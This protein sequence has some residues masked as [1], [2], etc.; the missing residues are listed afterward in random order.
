MDLE[1][2]ATDSLHQSL[3]DSVSL[4]HN[5]KDMSNL[6]T[7]ESNVEEKKDAL[8]ENEDS[9]A[10]SKNEMELDDNATKEDEWLDILGSGQ[11]LKKVSWA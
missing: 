1:M 8:K 3:E 9:S 6:R 10:S 2:S 11:L 7:A 5:S 4:S